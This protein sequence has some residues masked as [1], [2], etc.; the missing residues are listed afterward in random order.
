MKPAKEW[1]DNK[2]SALGNIPM[3]TEDCRSGKAGILGDIYN[4]NAGGVTTRT[5]VHL[6]NE[7][8]IRC[9]DDIE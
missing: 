5:S 1:L 9:L 6:G 2:V 7:G 8:V 4:D 3:A